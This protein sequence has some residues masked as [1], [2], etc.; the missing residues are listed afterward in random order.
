MYTNTYIYTLQHIYAGALVIFAVDAA[1]SR[2]HAVFMYIYIYIY[3]HTYMH[4]HTYTHTYTLQHICAGALV[5]FAVDASGSMALNR[6]NAA[7]G[8]AMNLLAEAYQSRDKICLIPFQVSIT[9]ICI[10]IYI[11][12]YIHIYTHTCTHIPF[13]ICAY[14]TCM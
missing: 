10:Y 14:I 7:K 4:T 3:T 2:M 13:Q 12:I 11:Y 6:M 9:Y 5:I 8:A 1:L